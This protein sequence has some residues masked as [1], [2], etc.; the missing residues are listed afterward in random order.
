MVQGGGRALR[1]DAAGGQ[2]DI[3]LLAGDEADR[4]GFRVLE[5]QAGAGDVVDPGLQRG[6]DAE[7]DEAGAD[8]DR[9]GVQQFVDELVRGLD[10]GDFF[11]RAGFRRLADGGGEE[12]IDVRQRI[13]GEVA[14]DDDAARLLVLQLFGEIDGDRGRE[15]LGTR[16]GRQKKDGRHAAFPFELNWTARCWEVSR[17]VEKENKSGSLSKKR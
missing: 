10:G 16:A 8:D 1:I 3:D 6:I 9:V 4:P 14:A 5:G 12:V 2:Y 13:G 17:C 7:V 11:G 15:R